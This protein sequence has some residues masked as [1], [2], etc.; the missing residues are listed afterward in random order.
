LHSVVVP[1][2]LKLRIMSENQVTE[3]T[4]LSPRVPPNASVEYNIDLLSKTPS[5]IESTLRVSE[6]LLDVNDR[7]DGCFVELNGLAATTLLK[8]PQH[9]FRNSSRIFFQ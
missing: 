1:S 6:T 8:H 4:T 5:G 9:L 3:V 7:L 2:R